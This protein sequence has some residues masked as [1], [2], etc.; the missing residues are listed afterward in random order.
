[1]STDRP[2][3]ADRAQD[4]RDRLVTVALGAFAE[5]GY[6]GVSLDA[7]AAEAGVTRGALHHHFT[8]REGLFVAVVRRIDAE[9]AEA[10]GEAAAPHRD[11]WTAFRAGFHRYLAEVTLPG[12][13]R[14]LFQ[15]A[16]A[17]LGTR[18]FD[19]LMDSGFGDMVDT[20]SSLIRAGRLKPVDPT[21]LG[22]MFNG[23]ALTLADWAASDPSRLPA[24]QAALAALFDGIEG[25]GAVAQAWA[26]AGGPGA[27]GI[28]EGAE[29]HP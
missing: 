7:L 3:R 9:L 17:V 19:I 14:I 11:S 12:R 28:A 27:D 2:S 23:A 18:A 29:Q 10:W 6:A 1:M 21:A 5:H 15:D 4:T 24:A 16:P 26:V 8:N 13:R 25:S 22:H 20:L